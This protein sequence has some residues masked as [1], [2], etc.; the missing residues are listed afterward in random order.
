M[1]QCDRRPLSVELSS[2]A[3]NSLPGLVQQQITDGI[4][5]SQPHSRIRI[6]SFTVHLI[7]RVYLLSQH[8]RLWQQAAGFVTPPIGWT[9]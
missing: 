1:Q 7:F 4:T 9:S 8:L 6:E 5:T 3:P 2:S